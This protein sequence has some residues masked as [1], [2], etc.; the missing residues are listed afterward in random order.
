MEKMPGIN[1]PPTIAE[2]VIFFDQ[3]ADS[4]RFAILGAQLDFHSECKNQFC[5]RNNMLHPERGS[6]R[7]LTGGSN[8]SFERDSCYARPTAIV[9]RDYYYD[10]GLNV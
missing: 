5:C 6:A 7:P 1:P 2:K 3:T 9:K 10:A 4:H 8:K